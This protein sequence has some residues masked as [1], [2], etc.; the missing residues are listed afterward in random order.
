MA[1]ICALDIHK[2]ES[3][4]V[5]S[6]VHHRALH[7][8]VRRALHLGSLLSLRCGGLLVAAVLLPRLLIWST[9]HQMSLDQSVWGSRVPLGA[10]E[11]RSLQINGDRDELSAS[12]VKWRSEY[13]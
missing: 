6:H 9:R 10:K 13:G 5:R 8:A 7:L 11:A 12:G 4:P 2:N 1:A 3:L